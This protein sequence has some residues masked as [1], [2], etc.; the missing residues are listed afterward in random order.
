MGAHVSGELNRYDLADNS[1]HPL[2]Q[3]AVASL[4][5]DILARSEMVTYKSY[6]ETS[7]SALVTMPA[8]LKLDSKN[9]AIVL[10]HGRPT[11]KTEDYFDDIAAALAGGSYI[12]IAPNLQS[13]TGYGK[14]FQTAHVDN[15]GGGD[16]KDTVAAKQFL[17][18]SG[19][20]DPNRVG[21]FG[22]SYGGFMTLMAVGNTHDEFAAGVQ[23]FGIINWRTMYR[24]MDE[25]LKAYLRSLMGTP[26]Q[27]PAG[28][29]R[30]SPPT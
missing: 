26:E 3:L 25:S 13:S 27:N 6:D 22:E 11:G 21:I 18:E 8:N 16:L 4:R 24:D 17:I 5:P 2:T 29:D 28:Y 20:V 10:P 14:T 9:P 12:I 15:L 23:W 7:I 30:A 19:Y 1:V